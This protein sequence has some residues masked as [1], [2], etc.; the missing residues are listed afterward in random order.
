VTDPG[1]DRPGADAASADD[2]ARPAGTVLPD[3]DPHRPDVVILRPRTIEPLG[4]PVAVHPLE[5][6]VDP[7]WQPGPSGIS[8]LNVPDDDT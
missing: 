3:R 4:A 7:T 6:M 5:S 8:L 2:D 1:A